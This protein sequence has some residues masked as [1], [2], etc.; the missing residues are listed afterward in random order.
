MR[1]WLME[2]HPRHQTLLVVVLEKA[3]L[4]TRRGGSDGGARRRRSAATAERGDGGARRRRSAATAAAWA[5]PP[6][7]LAERLG[8][9][10]SA[11]WGLPGKG[12]GRGGGGGVE[13]APPWDGPIPP[14]LML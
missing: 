9:Q 3:R 1:K 8:C 6:A 12:G 11:G 5:A 14:A 7:R 13:G 4:D 10:Q 2:L